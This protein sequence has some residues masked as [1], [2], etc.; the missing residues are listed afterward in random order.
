MIPLNDNPHLEQF[1]NTS[2][3]G[4][5][6]VGKLGKTGGRSMSTL[7]SFSLTTGVAIFPVERCP[8]NQK[9]NSLGVILNP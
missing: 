2:C 4:M 1:L 3:V 7:D 5:N 9:Q 6:G 8:C